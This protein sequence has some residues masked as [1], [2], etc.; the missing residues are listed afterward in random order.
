MIFMLAGSI[1]TL[2]EEEAEFLDELL[3]KEKEYEQRVKRE[4]FEG[5]Q[6]F[7]GEYCYVIRLQT[8]IFNMFF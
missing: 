6:E 7:R 4:E 8:N 3:D 1:K 2:D 5:L